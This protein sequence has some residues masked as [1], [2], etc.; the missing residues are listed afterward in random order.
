MIIDTEI[1]L[2]LVIAAIV[3][4]IIG[5]ERKIANKPAGIRTLMLISVGSALFTIVSLTAFSNRSTK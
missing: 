3:G 1:L 4:G 5:Y 2:R